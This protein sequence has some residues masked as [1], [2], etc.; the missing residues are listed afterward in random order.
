MQV[1]LASRKIL[2]E[3]FTDIWTIITQLD[4]LQ[5]SNKTGFNFEIHLLRATYSPLRWKKSRRQYW[6]FRFRLQKLPGFPNF[7]TDWHATHSMQADRCFEMVFIDIH[8]ND[9]SSIIR[10]NQNT[11]HSFVKVN[12]LNNAP[13]VDVFGITMIDYMK[14]KVEKI[15][16]ILFS[17]SKRIAF[18]LS[19]FDVH[20]GQIAS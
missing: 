14:T 6:F 15:A 9:W 16:G 4:Y 8:G 1:C 11:Y 18:N 17:V 5:Y 12:F 20:K 13:I 2:Q 19:T 10:V 3:R 7:R